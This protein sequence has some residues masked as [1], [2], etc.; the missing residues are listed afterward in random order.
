MCGVLGP[1]VKTRYLSWPLIGWNLFDFSTDNAERNSTKHKGKQDINV[2]YHVCVLGR[3]GKQDDRPS[4][5]LADTFSISPLELLNGIQQ[6]LKEEISQRPP[7]YLWFFWSRS[8][9]KDGCPG[10]WLSDIFD[11][12]FKTA[13]RNSTKLYSKQNLIVFYKCCVCRVERKNKMAA[14]ASD[15]LRNFSVLLW[16]RWTEF[17]KT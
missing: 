16:H 15:W 3:S 10:L 7:S 4:L 12:S 8:E 14:L 1:I 11:F 9:K 13:E 17:N 5:W 2:H 6:N